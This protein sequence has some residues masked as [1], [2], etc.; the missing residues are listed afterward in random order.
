MG[1][2]IFATNSSYSFDMGYGGFF[3]LRKNIALA[4]DKEFGENYACIAFCHTE[5]D[6]TVND[7]MSKSI[8]TRKHLDK[9]YGDILDFLYASDEGGKTTHKTCL[10]IYNLIK[11]IDFGRKGFRYAAYRHNDYEEFKKFLRECYS[12]HRKMRWK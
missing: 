6:Y 12:K 5:E 7:K 11:N 1:V 8:I 3:N 4:M 9:R 10:N 2:T